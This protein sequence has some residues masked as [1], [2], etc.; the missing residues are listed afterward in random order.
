MV[1]VGSRPSRLSDTDLELLQAQKALEMPQRSVRAS[2]VDSYVQYCSVWTPIVDTSLLERLQGNEAS[3]LLLNALFLA[4]SRVSLS[5]TLLTMAEEFYRKARLLFMLGHEIDT[6]TSII[7]VTLIQWYNP[8]G[9]EHI[10]TS[11][12]GFW[13]RIAAGMAYQVGLHREPVA[14]K[15]KELR[16]RLWWSIVVSIVVSYIKHSTSNATRPD[17][18]LYS[19][20]MTLSQSAQE[21][22]EPSTLRIATSLLRPFLILQCK[23]Q[24]HDCLWHSLA[25]SACW[26]I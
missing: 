17:M 4:G 12:S 5:K 11:T 13:I 15:D 6:L 25:S 20:E 7:A 2:L 21:G 3:P 22:R 1:T 26:Q 24:R 8:T 23:V 16:R 19:L 10:S 9:P 18:I 14:Q